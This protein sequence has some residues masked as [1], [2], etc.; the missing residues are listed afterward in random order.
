MDN[1]DLYESRK[2]AFG[3]RDKFVQFWLA[4][5]D[6]A[7]KKEAKW[8][9]DAADGVRTY[10]GHDKGSDSDVASTPD[11]FNI[12]NSNIETILPAIYNST[13]A[14]DVR[15][16][17]GDKDPTAK[18]VSQMLERALSYSIDAYD[19]DDLMRSILFDGMVAGRGMARVRYKPYADDEGINYQEV[20]CEYVHWSRFRIGMGDTWEDVPWIAFEHFLSRDELKQLAPNKAADVQLDCQTDGKPV[21]SEGTGVQNDVW[22]RARVWEIWD[23]ES[24]SVI[25]IATGYPQA[26]LREEED[27]LELERFFPVPKPFQPIQTPGNLTPVA[28]YTIYRSLVEELNVVQ[29]RIRNLTAICKARGGYAAGADSLQRIVE[30]DDGEIAA[31][32][33]VE[34][35]MQ[36]GGLD[37]AIV[38][39]PIEQIA[40]V[41]QILVSQR[42]QIKQ[43]IYEVTGLS[44]ILRGAS[45]ASETATAQE[46]KSQWGSQRIQRAQWEVQRF[47]R[48]IFRIKAEIIAQKFEPKTLMTITGIKLL[49]REEH[50]QAGQMKQ[51]FEQ[52]VQQAQQ[53]GQQPPQMPPIPPE[54]IKALSEPAI[55]DVFEVMQSDEMR[56][57]RVDIESDSTIRADLSRMQKQMNEFLQGTAQFIGAVGPAVQ[58]GQ[59]PD[60]LAMEIYSAFARNFKLGKQAEDALESAGEEA[61][62]P[63]PPKPNPEAEKAK[64]QMEM[65]KQKQ[66]AAQ[67]MEQAKM[68]ADQA[69]QQADMQN[70]QAK[71]Q[72]ATESEQAKLQ[73]EGQKLEMKAQADMQKAEVDSQLAREKMMAEIEL[74]REEMALRIELEREKAQHDY[75]LAQFKAQSEMDLKREV[76]EHSAGLK[77]EDVKN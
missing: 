8:R 3:T 33:G 43:T 11:E 9:E 30:L 77:E 60:S 4:S 23:K 6:A 7:D 36:E 54:I 40:K 57:Y 41:I 62:K 50:Q 52:A 73:L 24:R 66:Q 67:Q 64:A 65:E 35:A 58:A 53:S 47:A 61:G 71:L 21:D 12:F 22:Q 74:K 48:D 55:E 49:S 2:E 15:R 19:F 75:D 44:D 69:K 76:A 26:P 13:P 25:F 18:V 20:S 68:Q 27:P 32:E 31:L 28:P 42:E 59:M 10:R 16:R 14:P 37:K 51:Q 34:M 39:W 5:I 46:I 72:A 63:K 17:F 38:W 56:G 29:A 45:K 70:E 1:S